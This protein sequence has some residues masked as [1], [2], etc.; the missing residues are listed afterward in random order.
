MFNKNNSIDS[1]NIQKKIKQIDK[2]EVY[3]MKNEEKGSRSPDKK[4]WR[5]PNKINSSHNNSKELIPFNIEQVKM[6]NDNM[7]KI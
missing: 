2:K 5:A 7:F 1:I 3:E 6:K 4:K